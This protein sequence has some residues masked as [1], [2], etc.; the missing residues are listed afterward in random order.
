MV[1]T[2]PDSL[3]EE[4]I[5]NIH[6]NTCWKTRC[7]KC[8]E[9]YD[10]GIS[11]YRTK[12]FCEK[13]IKQGAILNGE[14]IELTINYW[15][16]STKTARE[17]IVYNNNLSISKI[18]RLIQNIEIERK[19]YKTE[20]INAEKQL[21][22]LKFLETYFV[23]YKDKIENNKYFEDY[24]R[25]ITNEKEKCISI[26]FIYMNYYFRLPIIME[27]YQRLMQAHKS[28]TSCF[29]CFKKLETNEIKKRKSKILCIDC[30]SEET[31][32]HFVKECPICYEKFDS[33]NSYIPKCGNGHYICA[34]CFD[35]LKYYTSSCPMCRGDL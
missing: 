17:K 30:F 5:Y 24:I 27:N 28:K 8:T 33:S 3:F 12:M 32:V 26:Y 18:K 22:Y 2:Y 35:K 25:Y 16:Y 20:L 10:Y 7:K 23:N 11:N 21:K 13:C 34:R 19:I 4:E 1:S 31:T 9:Y 6:F 29:D 15:C 14:K